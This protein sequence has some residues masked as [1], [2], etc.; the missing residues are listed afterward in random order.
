MHIVDWV[1]SVTQCTYRHFELY[2][3]HPVKVKVHHIGGSG[4]SPV[5][6]IPIPTDKDPKLIP[7]PKTVLQPGLYEFSIS[8]DDG[9]IMRR[10]QDFSSQV[11]INADFAAFSIINIYPVPVKDSFAVDFD[12]LAPMDINMTVVDNMGHTYY[13]KALHFPLAGRNKHVVDMTPQWPSGLYHAIFQYAD[14]SSES[15]NFTVAE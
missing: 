12:L 5:V 9:T 15:L 4:K 13:Q 8:M 6:S 2:H 11:V 3:P 14:G 1:E 7:V 10:Y